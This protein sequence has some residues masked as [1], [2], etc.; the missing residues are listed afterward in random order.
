MLALGMELEAPTAGVRGLSEP[1][2]IRSKL[3]A[4][5]L[6]EQLIARPRVERLLATLIDRH[7]VVVVAATAGAGKTTAVARAA[8]LV[9]RPV[10]WLTVDRT[11]TAPGRLVTY[12]EAALARVVPELGGVAT[13]ALA[14]GV[15]HAEAA[16][17]LADAVGEQPV[18]LVLDDLERLGDEGSAWAVVESVS[19]YASET[20]RLVLVSRRQIPATV[21]ADAGGASIA[22]AGDRVLA[23]TVVEA[24]EALARVA[25]V[26]VD[27]S[28]AVVATGGWVTGVLFEA[29]RSA[30]HVTGMGGESDPLHGYLATHILD[31]LR[32]AEREFLVRTALLDEV[33]AA[34][35]E[36]LGELDGGERLAA[37]RG[38][39]LPVGWDADGA[40][41]CHPRF[42]EYLL[43]RLG[44]LHAGERRALQLA[45]GRLL[46]DEGHDEE[47][48]EELLRAGAPHEALD[49]ARRAIVPVIERLDIAVA[50]RWL[51]ALA[52]VSPAGDAAFA[53]AELMLGL[54]QGDFRRGER[55]ADRVATAGEREAIASS[56]GRA[57]AL[58]VWCYLVVGRL[59]DAHAVLAVA[60]KGHP[61]DVMRYA[62]P[63]WEPAPPPDRPE[64][65]GD[66]FDAVV[67]AADVGYGR[68]A[69]LLEEGSSRWV[70]AISGA[71][72]I[73][74][75]RAIGRTQEALELYLRARERGLADG[76]LESWR[77]AEVLIDAG[78]GDEAR[79]AITRG[80]RLGKASGSVMYELF[81]YPPEA[82][83]ALRIEHDPSA[84]RAALDRAERHRAAQ[85]GLY[86]YDEVDTWYGLALLLEDEDR[87]A[88]ERLRRAVERMVTCDRMLEL[89]TA[90][91]YLAEAEWRAGDEEAA[92][93]AADLALWAAGR[94][95]SNHVLLQALADCPAVVS[96]RIDAEPGAASA[97][98]ELGR[99]LMAQGVT[100]H[101]PVHPAVEL[102][103]FGTAE[104]LA[105]GR[106]VR[107]RIAKASE[108]LAYLIT[109]AGERAE[110]AELLDA[111]FDG[112]DD[113][114][115]RAYLRQAVHQLRQVLPEGAGL[116]AEHGY[117]Q[118]GDE[119]RASSES[120]RFEALIAEA[121]RL[122][123]EAR[124]AATLQAIAVFD[125]G[126]YLP[127]LHS[128]WVDERRRRLADLAAD[129]RYEAAELAFAAGRYGEAQRL[130]DRVLEADPFR[131]GAWRLKMRIADA[132]GD[133]DG[134]IRAYQSCRRALASLNTAPS[135]TTEHLLQR[136]R[137]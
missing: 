133:G 101:A 125:A 33:T 10:A 2:V 117:V 96:R 7:R 136:L 110:R 25:T 113:D 69:H 114:S 44:R 124:L 131:E 4:P 18:L 99:A 74:A 97:W 72:R 24:A 130:D 67:L 39:H 122:R 20:M 123:D 46:A 17:M 37:L 63:F 49:P 91:V 65:T 51:K 52:E 16:G 104:I 137:R 54:G 5:A 47:A 107:P 19:R 118:L 43:A 115:T 27:A 93:R 13:G 135:P 41:R 29:W 36:A 50:E 109:R 127:G 103:E 87:A 3:K 53:T 35:A 132:F 100:V 31:Q 108:L 78:R 82:K 68:L 12:L 30:G 26:P 86:V 66:A 40:M 56:S 98:H 70:D 58:M 1:A 9:D 60:E 22:A 106:R 45:H 64:L 85:P 90:A 62:L 112:R 84:A 32:P 77:G 79:E 95:G 23:F 89:P 120:T 15:P 119:V 57:A 42:R 73:A 121:A 88:L 8:G 48:T 38:A 71:R 11:D 55:V 134:V 81:T 111:L 6:P 14:A 83:L 102:R 116:V 59:E 80:R 21:L 94:L 34:R 129:A 28:D 105:A 126:E 76:Q 61:L 128:G 92:D 75:L